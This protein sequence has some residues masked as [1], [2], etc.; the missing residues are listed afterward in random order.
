M[1][2]EIFGAMRPRLAPHQSLPNSRETNPCWPQKIH[3]KRELISSHQKA[4]VRAETAHVV[5]I[6]QIHLMSP[7]LGSSSIHHFP[8]SYGSVD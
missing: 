7:T 8:E 6:M 2:P 4:G 5:Q 1:P 3:W